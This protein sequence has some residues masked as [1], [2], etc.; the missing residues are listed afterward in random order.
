MLK[1]IRNGLKCYV[2]INI[3]NEKMVVYLKYVKWIE[4]FD[5]VVL[6]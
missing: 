5:K 3:W 4:V 1:K 6:Y 2:R